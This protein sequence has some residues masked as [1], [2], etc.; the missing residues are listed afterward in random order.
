MA[1]VA[2][3]AG[4]VGFAHGIG[5]AA[6][7]G[8]HACIDPPGRHACIDPP[9]RHACIDRARRREIASPRSR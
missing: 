2:I 5:M 4:M 8:R 3:V 1:N 7:P 9:G 6:V